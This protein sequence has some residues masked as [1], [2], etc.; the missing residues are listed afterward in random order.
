MSKHFFHQPPPFRLLKRC[1]ETNN[2][3]TP[4][5]TIPSHLQLVHGVYILYMHLDTRTVRRFRCPEVEI[6]MPPCFEVERIVTIVKVSEFGEKVK[7]RFRVE[8]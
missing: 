5:E 3:S 1:I 2:T 4:F 8:F 6:F 7:V